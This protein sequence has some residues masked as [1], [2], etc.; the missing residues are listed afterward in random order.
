[1]KQSI[2]I[3]GNSDIG[4][5]NSDIIIEGKRRYDQWF[6]KMRI[7]DTYLKFLRK[8]KTTTF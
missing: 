1:M 8:E 7:E 2:E 3:P 6:K 4:P 5:G